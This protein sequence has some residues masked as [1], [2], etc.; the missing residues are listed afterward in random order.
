[1]DVSIELEITTCAECGAV[2]GL[3]PAYHRQL[4]QTGKTFHCPNG[5]LA[6]YSDGE[7]ER[8][9]DE[10][11]SRKAQIKKQETLIS[12]QK[13]QITKLQKANK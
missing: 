7:N 8:L 1:M 3:V 11:Q 5:H 4:R 2:F 6:C 9:K 13:G 12:N 10:L